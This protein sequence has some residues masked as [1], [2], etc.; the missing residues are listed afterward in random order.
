[1]EALRPLQAKLERKTRM[2]IAMIGAGYVGLVSGTCCVTEWDVFGALDLSRIKA[3]MALRVIVDLRN[4]YRPDDVARAGFRYLG[5]GR[6]RDVA[7]MSPI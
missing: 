6:G 2:R 5:I 7:A 3:S 1:M 4:I